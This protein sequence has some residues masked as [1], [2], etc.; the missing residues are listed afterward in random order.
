MTRH[1]ASR[2]N[3]L[4]ITMSSSSSSTIR[5]EPRCKGTPACEPVIVAKSGKFRQVRV[6]RCVPECVCGETRQMARDLPRAESSHSANQHRR[7]GRLSD[8]QP[9]W[10]GP[11]EMSFALEEQDPKHGG[12]ERRLRSSSSS[13]SSLLLESS[14]ANRFEN[15]NEGRGGGWTENRRLGPLPFT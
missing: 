6:L 10:R 9:L 4:R 14:Q 1:A 11:E 12:E 2:P 13:C 3:W 8:P 7:A 5:S 15:D